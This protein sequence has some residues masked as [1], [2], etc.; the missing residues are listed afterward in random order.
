[1][2]DARLIIRKDV[3][4]AERVRAR[5]ARDR[6]GLAADA[7]PRCA[8]VERGERDV[9]IDGRGVTNMY[10]RARRAARDRAGERDG[11]AG[12]A[13]NVNDARRVVLRGR[14]GVADSRVA[15]GDEELR[16]RRA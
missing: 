6:H 2:T 11:V 13:L 7:R 9:A 10:A 16:A 15:A 14:A 8:E 5:A 12:G 4:R 3:D 1:G